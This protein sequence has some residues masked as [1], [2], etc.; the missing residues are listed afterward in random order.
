M[1]C[2]GII[3]RMDD[4]GRIVIPKEIRNN[5][6]LSEGEPLEI[7]VDTQEEMVCFKKYADT[8]SLAKKCKKV[9]EKYENRIFTVSFAENIT[10]VVTLSGTVG[11]SEK[12]SC[13][14]FDINIGIA[15]ALA[16]AGEIDYSEFE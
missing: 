2:T 12:N 1:K 8:S 14:S 4:L 5:L 15:Y 9:V 3:R 13:D 16:D 7:Y 11:K 10:T 6:D